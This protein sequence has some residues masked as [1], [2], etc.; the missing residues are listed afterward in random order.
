MCDSSG[1]VLSIATR[2]QYGNIVDNPY[3]ISNAT[4][5]LMLREGLEL[6]VLHPGNVETL[7][8]NFEPLDDKEFLTNMAKWIAQASEYKFG[9]M[10]DYNPF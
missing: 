1:K 6:V 3:F 9:V 4:K 2:N 10:V 8:E 7:S 5:N